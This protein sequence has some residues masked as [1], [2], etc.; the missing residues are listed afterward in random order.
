MKKSSAGNLLLIM[1]AIVCIVGLI[2]PSMAEITPRKIAIFPFEVISQEDQSFIGRGMG[3]ML[4][5]RVGQGDE[6]QVKC[7]NKPFETYPLSM[8]N[9]LM[10]AI[11]RSE[12]LQGVGFLLMGSVTI[13]GNA[14]STDARL[15]DVTGSREP[16]N[17]HETGSGMGDVIRH[18]A[19]VAEKVRI[20]LAGG[21]LSV[22]GTSPGIIKPVETSVLSMGT[23]SLGGEGALP[24]Q[25]SQ[26]TGAII[27]RDASIVPLFV[28]QSLSR[29]ITGL[30]ILDMNGAREVA[31]IDAQQLTVFSWN[32]QGLV[33]KA[34]LKGKHYQTFMGVDAMDIDADGKDELFISVLDRKNQLRSLVVSGG[35]RKLTI[36]AKDLPWFFR[37]VKIDGQKQLLG[38]KAGQDQLFW[39]DIH[40]L[41]F[42][43][44]RIIPGPV[45]MVGSGGIF[46]R[47][48][49]HLTAEGPLRMAWF[50][51][52]GYL[53]VGKENFEKEWISDGSWGSTDLFVVYDQ[54]KN[55]VDRRVYLNSRVA[56][57]DVDG[58][59][60][61]DVIAVVNNDLSRGL[62]SGFRKFTRGY[63][64]FL[65]WSGNT[66][67]ERW[68]THEIS[69]YVADFS[70]E[71]MNGDGHPE[72]VYA[73]VVASDR[74]I[75]NARSN[76]VVQSVGIFEK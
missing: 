65:N 13:A 33:K 76:I 48:L 57:E 49:G 58:N 23:A 45:K 22:D 30:T 52:D 64:S 69:G 46:G 66:L 35:E 16:V 26:N 39:G 55:G 18:A 50:D 28:N 8:S 25:A 9:G 10:D 12:E 74:L 40:L 32:N 37:V 51:G 36:V 2:T 67:V 6:I 15:V 60:H 54:G 70:L 72:L 14:V 71:D 61:A 68:K 34:E 38:Q 59:G 7:L 24:G 17:I 44:R 3:K 4:C 75:G 5:T 27:R 41:S 20:V 47:A 21:T 56:I 53:N 62:L 43:G 31:V 63:I 11:A 42:D 73:T 1:G 19:A 29:E